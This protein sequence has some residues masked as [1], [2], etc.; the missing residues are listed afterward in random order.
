MAGRPILP[1]NLKVTRGTAKRCR[2]NENE[3]GWLLN[4][5]GLLSGLIVKTN[6]YV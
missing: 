6:C 2:M 3:P 1:T 4:Q 5:I